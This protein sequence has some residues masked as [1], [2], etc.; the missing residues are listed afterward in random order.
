MFR[1]CAGVG[2]L[3]EEAG[4]GPAGVGAVI[5]DGVGIADVFGGEDGEG[6][7]DAQG[8]AG[9]GAVEFVEEGGE[10]AEEGVDGGCAECQ[11]CAGTGG[12]V[13]VL[14]A[15]GLGKAGV[16]FPVQLPPAQVQPR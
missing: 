9:I 6:A 12:I 3:E 13:A 2:A 15:E 1:I 10:G 4:V 16:V 8:G 7:D 11:R 5:G 14:A